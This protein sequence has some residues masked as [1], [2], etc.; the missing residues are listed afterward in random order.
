[1]TLLRLS[2]YIRN[3]FVLYGV[4]GECW[5]WRGNKKESGQRDLNPTPMLFE[6]GPY[7][8]NKNT[9]LRT[10]LYPPLFLSHPPGVIRSLFC[11]FSE[12]SDFSDF[13]GM[14]K[15]TWTPYAQ[16]AVMPCW[17]YCRRAANMNDW[18]GRSS[19]SVHCYVVTSKEFYRRIR[20]LI[21]YTKTKGSGAWR[22]LRPARTKAAQLQSNALSL[23][24]ES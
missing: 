1:M 22:T 10:I 13:K 12:V 14:K 9:P 24:R 15:W 20:C 17:F 19:R 3:S 21:L 2:I 5:E 23:I 7:K 6:A 8:C 11:W 18:D 16:T 4:Q